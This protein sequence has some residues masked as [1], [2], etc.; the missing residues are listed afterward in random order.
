MYSSV[1]ILF[2]VIGGDV[3]KNENPAEPTIIPVDP[4][5]CVALILW[6]KFALFTFIE[7]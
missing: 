6:N 5:R 4:T 3:C 1:S 2:A 7:T